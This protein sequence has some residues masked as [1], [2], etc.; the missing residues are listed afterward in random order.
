[1]LRYK[2]RFNSFFKCS[3]VQRSFYE[4]WIKIIIIIIIIIIIYLFIYFYPKALHKLS[5]VEL[6]KL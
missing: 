6:L 5:P 4:C 1:M 2:F 3:T